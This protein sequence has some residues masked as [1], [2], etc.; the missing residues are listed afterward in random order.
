MK[1][2]FIII[3]ILINIFDISTA[4]AQTPDNENIINEIKEKVA[5]KV[6]EIR[7]S[8]QFVI[9]GKVKSKNNE[10][11]ILISD[12]GDKKI[13][14]DKTAKYYWINTIGKKI[15]ITYSN[16]AVD[17][18]FAVLTK[19]FTIDETTASMAIGKFNTFVFKGMVIQE[20]VDKKI[21]I[22][23]EDKNTEIPIAIQTATNL[24]VLNKN[25]E[26]ATVKIA[27]LKEETKLLIRGYYNTEKDNEIIA[28]RVLIFE[29]SPLS[30]NTPTP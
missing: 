20:P 17:D 8:K 3:I 10:S 1:L 29:K 19:G 22:R 24:S 15:N 26:N 16:L 23:L 14:T 9:S 30:K 25:G 28:T 21:T 18:D 6:A 27:D 11:F 13:L 2:L 4:Y 12:D 5:S 7:Q